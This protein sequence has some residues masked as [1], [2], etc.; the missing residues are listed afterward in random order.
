VVELEIARDALADAD[1]KRLMTV[2]GIEMVVATGLLAAI[3]GR[4]PNVT[5]QALHVSDSRRF[6][7]ATASSRRRPL[8]PAQ[9]RHAEEVQVRE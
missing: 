3:G 9:G 4:A 1:T 2:P 5:A 7:P 8:R 6:V